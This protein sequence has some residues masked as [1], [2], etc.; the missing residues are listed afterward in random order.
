MA[1]PGDGAGAVVKTGL[2]GDAL[3]G[4]GTGT[5]SGAV[6]AVADSR[7]I[8]A[9]IGEGG[10]VGRSLT[11][12]KAGIKDVSEALVIQRVDLSTGQGQYRPDYL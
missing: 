3:H 2:T 5:A 6:G 11:G 9:V 1:G 7:L 8:G 10:V 12:G 4:D